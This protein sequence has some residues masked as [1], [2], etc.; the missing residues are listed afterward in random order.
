[1]QNYKYFLGDFVAGENLIREISPC[2]SEHYITDCE[3]EQYITEYESAVTCENWLE[4][5]ATNVSIWPKDSYD[6][7][8]NLDSSANDFSLADYFM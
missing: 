5:D 8:D 4:G 7:K 2:E 3:Y 6:I 1:M